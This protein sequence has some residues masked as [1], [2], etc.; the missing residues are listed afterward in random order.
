MTNGHSPGPWKWRPVYD[1]TGRRVA[2]LLDCADERRGPVTA[3]REDRAFWAG[4]P[5]RHFGN[6]P[7]GHLL[8]AAP[9]LLAALEALV[10]IANGGQRAVDDDNGSGLADT[11][12]AAAA[13]IAQARGEGGAS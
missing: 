6:S 7:D 2:L 13:A 5:D 1:E 11:L 9:A 4:Y 8:A 12:E 3:I 10:A